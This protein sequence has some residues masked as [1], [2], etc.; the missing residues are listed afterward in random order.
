M[1]NK[2]SNKSKN[3]SDNSSNK[4]NN[5]NKK[6][7]KSNKFAQQ[8]FPYSVFVVHLFLGFFLKLIESLEC[9]TLPEAHRKCS[10]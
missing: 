1:N 9:M 4:N 7:K 5:N 3:S 8:T 10:Q 2:D 6:K